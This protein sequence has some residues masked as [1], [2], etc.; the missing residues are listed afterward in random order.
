MGPSY[1][2]YDDGYGYDDD[3]YGE[4]GGYGDGYDDPY[5]EYEYEDDDVYNDPSMTCLKLTKKFS[6][7]PP[8]SSELPYKCDKVDNVLTTK[9][10]MI[11]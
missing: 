11:Q 1:G 6:Y 10:E 8:L 4:G 3:P 9:M 5:G 2:G 7:V